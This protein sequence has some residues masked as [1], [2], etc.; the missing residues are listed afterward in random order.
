MHLSI[1]MSPIGKRFRNYT[2]NY[3]ALINNTAIDWFMA[4]PEEALIEVAE[5]YID[6]IDVP[7]D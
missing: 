5:K 4:W 1:C 6:R 7:E 2:R 3:P